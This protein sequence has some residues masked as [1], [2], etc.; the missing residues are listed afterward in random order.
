MRI[1]A[2][3]DELCSVTLGSHREREAA[4]SATRRSVKMSQEQMVQENCS[5]PSDTF[6]GKTWL[7]NSRSNSMSCGS[8]SFQLRLKCMLC[9]YTIV[10]GMPKPFDSR[11][12]NL[13]AISEMA[14]SEGS[15]DSPKNYL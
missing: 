12:R 7:A 13:I 6:L 2:F 3:G 8:E 10:K 4:P 15:N 5:I 1:P 11:A 9:V 14:P